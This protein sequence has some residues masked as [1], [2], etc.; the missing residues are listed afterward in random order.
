MEF[1]DCLNGC[2]RQKSTDRTAFVRADSIIER[3]SLINS[4][5]V[6]RIL[7]IEEQKLCRPKVP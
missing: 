3:I 7:R 4:F 6:L 2:T 5:I 1:L